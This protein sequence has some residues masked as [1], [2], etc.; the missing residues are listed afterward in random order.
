M[1]YQLY[2]IVLY[3]CISSDVCRVVLMVLSV[4]QAS[5]RAP[6]L[7]VRRIDGIV[8]VSGEYSGAPTEGQTYDYAR[9]ILSLMTEEP[10]PEGKVRILPGNTV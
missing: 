1:L 5:T 8:R 9:T 7:R 3:C 4:F 2:C 6:P 10:H